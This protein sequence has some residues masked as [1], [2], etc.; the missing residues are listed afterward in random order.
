MKIYISCPVIIDIKDVEEA[1]SKLREAGHK[2][3]YW[4]RHSP[5]EKSALRD[6]TAVVFLSPDN[7]F[8][9]NLPSGCYREY[10]E[11]IKNRLPV[12]LY[13][14]TTLHETKTKLYAAS[15]STGTTILRGLA[16]SGITIE[17]SKRNALGHS[18]N[19]EADNVETNKSDTDEH[20]LLLLLNK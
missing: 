10:N 1:A 5:Y 14:T 8:N 3:T 17:Q 12:Y 11:A 20:I 7:N 19:V 4:D 15:V 13:Y 6:A 18:I 2:V 16:G 9:M